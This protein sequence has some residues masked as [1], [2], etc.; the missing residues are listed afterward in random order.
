[1]ERLVFSDGILAFDTS[2]NAGQTYRL[3]QAAFGRTPD[4]PGLSHNI[5]LMDNGLVLHGLSDGFIVSAEFIALYGADS[6]NTTFL[7][8]LYANV[9]DRAPDPVGFNSWNTLLTT[10][11]L[12]R[13]DVLVGFSES[14]ENIALVANA[15]EN[16]I[17]LSPKS[18]PRGD[19][20]TTSDDF[21]IVGETA[22]G[23]FVATLGDSFT[24]VIVGEE[25][26]GDGA[27]TV[28]GTGTLGIG[29]NNLIVGREGTGTLVVSNGGAV[30]VS[31]DE[32][33]MLIGRSL[34]GGTGNVTLSGAGST[35]TVTGTTL[36]SLIV[37]VEGT[38]TLI[39]S[40]G[41]SLIVNSFSGKAE[42][43]LGFF[44]N[45]TGNITVSGAGSRITLTGTTG[46]LGSGPINLLA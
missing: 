11:A 1:M 37:G 43:T 31:A 14:L 9:L 16:G 41:G 38:G 25:A 32:I 12:D 46:N 29:S 2:G 45:S 26:T 17:L 35:I 15:I 21:L 10:G 28:S 20:R 24:G 30:N 34:T 36:A 33:F 18:G 40:D 27:V 23:S 22:V 4:T 39:V 44:D 7:T 42:T 3:Y 6:S 8:A 5:N 13:A 19:V